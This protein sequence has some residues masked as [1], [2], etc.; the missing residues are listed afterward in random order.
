MKRL[1]VIGTMVWDTIYRPGP[2]PRPAE[3]WGGIAYSLV[4][5]DAALA[6]EWDIVPLIKVGRDLAPSANQFLA[7]LTRRAPTARFVEVPEPNNRVTLHYQS[8]E[9]RTECL[10]GGVPGWTWAELGPMVDDLDAIY[11]NFISGF[12]LTQD[13]ARLLRRGFSGPLYA[14]FHSLYL[15]LGQHG[16]RIPQ[17]LGDPE[18]WFS[19]FD[20][21]QLNEDELHRTGP[22]PLAVAARALGAGVRLL[23]V[24]LGPRGS[25]YFS[26]GEPPMRRGGNGTRHQTIQ[27]ALI[28]APSVEAGDTTGC[29]DAFG[30][31]LAA[32]LLA[33]EPVES[34]IREANAVAG[35]NVRCSGAG[36][37]RHALRGGIAVP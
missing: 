17:A 11:V 12:E 1:G 27:T 4:A 13:T 20:V 8:G 37:L 14:D 26:R 28:P 5:L 9:R 29:G 35:R 3:E 7:D 23:V 31:T 33:G 19:C 18:G 36:G 25:V 22:D 15:G 24:T 2:G 6:P 34:A 30:A 10:V 32:R 21:V 16:V